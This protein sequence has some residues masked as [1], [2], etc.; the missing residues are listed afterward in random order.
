[1][2]MYLCLPYQ[3]LNLLTQHFLKT[4]VL[5]KFIRRKDWCTIVPIFTKLSIY[6]G[7]KLQGHLLLSLFPKGQGV[8][9]LY[10]TGC[11]VKSDVTVTWRWTQLCLNFSPVIYIKTLCLETS[12]CEWDNTKGHINTTKGR[13]SIFRQG[14]NVSACRILYCHDSTLYTCTANSPPCALLWAESMICPEKRMTVRQKNEHHCP[15]PHPHA[16][17]S[18]SPC[19][20]HV[21]SA[22]WCEDQQEGAMS[23]LDRENRTGT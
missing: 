10:T 2:R 23:D 3:C 4:Q 14:D 6:V 19:N 7:T 8:C 13:K 20:A 17:E 18:V 12:T 16:V 21:W 1:M 22:D 5:D 9:D 15:I 11:Q